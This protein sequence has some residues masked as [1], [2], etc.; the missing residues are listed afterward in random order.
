M[1]FVGT[2]NDDQG[3]LPETYIAAALEIDFGTIPRTLG[4]VGINYRQYRQSI[5]A[6]VNGIP[7][8]IVTPGA[9]VI[10]IEGEVARFYQTAR[11]ENYTVGILRAAASWADPG[12]YFGWEVSG[13]A[14]YVT[15]AGWSAG[16]RFA[17]GEIGYDP[18]IQT[19]FGNKFA[20][21]RPY[22]SYTIRGG[23][24]LFL[25]GEYINSEFYNLTSGMV[26]VKIRF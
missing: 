22:V 13:G 20:A 15:R 23:A 10:G 25:S 17:I 16:L 7:T 19:G 2:S 18:Q 11:S 6:E 24:E 12:S 1:F 26:G 9:R 21:I 5:L 4:R 14:T 8:Q 3:F